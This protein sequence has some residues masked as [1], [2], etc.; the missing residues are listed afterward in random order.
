[1][2]THPEQPPVHHSEGMSFQVDQNKRQ[3]I[4]QRWQRR[5]LIRRVPAGGARSPIEVPV[6]HMGL[7]RALKGRDQP[8]KLGQHETGQ[9]QHLRGAG[10]EIGEP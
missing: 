7:E 3:R 8:L 4:F 2:H 10:L 9:I 1:M 5:V 6:D